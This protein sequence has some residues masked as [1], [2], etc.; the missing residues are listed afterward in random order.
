[1][2][3]AVF[4]KSE[5]PAK[6]FSKLFCLSCFTKKRTFLYAFDDNLSVTLPVLHVLHQNET[7]AW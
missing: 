6:Y 2:H 3:D 4:K 1:V 5:M 7:T